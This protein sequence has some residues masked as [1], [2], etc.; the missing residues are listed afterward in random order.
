MA[1]IAS[2]SSFVISFIRQYVLNPVIVCPN[3]VSVPIKLTH[4]RCF[5]DSVVSKRVVIDLTQGKKTTTDNIAPGP[6]QWEVEGYVGGLP[7]ELSS[8]FMPSIGIMRD[9]LDGGWSQRQQVTFFDKYQKSWQVVV[10]HF[11]YE[12]AP[13]EENALLVRLHLVELNVQTISVSGIANDPVSAAAS[14]PDGTQ[15]GAPKSLGTSENSVQAPT[16]PTGQSVSSIP[17][18]MIQ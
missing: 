10:E 4:Y 3:G 8:R 17:G 2:N 11:E 12:P 7:Y 5:G 9:S 14:A 16:S 18:V 1:L 15:Y 6:H 13:D